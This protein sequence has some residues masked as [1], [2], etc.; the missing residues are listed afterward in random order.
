MAR[1]HHASVEEEREAFAYLH[2]YHDKEYSAVDCLSF[3]VMDKLGIT[4]AW[5]VD[6]DFGHRFVV[7]PGPASQV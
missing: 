4:E 5:A 6:S 2:K 7:R 1:I 3:V